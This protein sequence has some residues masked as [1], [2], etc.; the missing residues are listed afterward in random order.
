MLRRFVFAAAVAL[1]FGSALAAQ[2]KPQEKPKEPPKEA[3][4]AVDVTGTWDIAVETPQGSM[5]LVTTFKQEG[6][7][8]SGTQTSQMGDTALEGTV[9]GPDIAFVIVVNMQGQDLRI[10]YT[11]K[12]EG[13]A[14]S[15]AIEFDSFGTSTWAAKKRK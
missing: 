4:A 11:G 1:V 14:M 6:E 12:I 8:L 5:A 9:K 15:G 10:A 3:A 2:D 7:K 13:D